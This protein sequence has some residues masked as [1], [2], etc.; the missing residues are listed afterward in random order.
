MDEPLHTREHMIQ[1][2]WGKQ[3]A[4]IGGLPGQIGGLLGQQRQL[5]PL[6]PSIYGVTPLRAT[7]PLLLAQ[8]LQVKVLVTDAEPGSVF[9]SPVSGMGVR[10]GYKLSLTLRAIRSKQLYYSTFFP[11]LSMWVQSSRYSDARS[12][13]G[14]CVEP[15]NG[16][17]PEKVEL[18]G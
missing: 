17:Y 5:L 2:S 15:G 1:A 13:K 6:P 8:V 4:K 7:A 11:T 9:P 3:G 12:L 14:Q 18:K 16:A 10:K